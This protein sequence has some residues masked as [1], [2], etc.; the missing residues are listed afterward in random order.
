MPHLGR[1]EQ[2]LETE[3]GLYQKADKGLYEANQKGRNRV[4]LVNW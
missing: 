3:Q 4:F 1:F 2:G